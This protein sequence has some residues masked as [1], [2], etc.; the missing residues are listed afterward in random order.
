MKPDMLWKLFTVVLGSAIMPLVGWVWSVNVE[1]T[2]LRND[3]GDLETR[4]AE[5]KDQVVDLD[6]A[7]RTLIGVEKDV[8]H[9]REILD[10]IEVLVTR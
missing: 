2:Q 6:R 5:I 9:I 3:L 4:H 10:R 7:A 1:V 8:Q